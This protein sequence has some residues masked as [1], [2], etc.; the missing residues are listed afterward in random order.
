VYI[1][2]DA[3]CATAY[4]NFEPVTELCAARFRQ[5]SCNGDSGNALFRELRDGRFVAVGTVSYGEGCALPGFPGVY[6][7]LLALQSWVQSVVKV[8]INTPV[9]Y[10][11]ARSGREALS[12]TSTFFTNLVNASALLG[13]RRPSP[14][15]VYQIDPL[16]NLGT[17]PRECGATRVWCHASAVPRECVFMALRSCAHAED[18]FRLGPGRSFVL[19]VQTCGRRT[20]TTFDTVIIAQ[21]SNPYRHGVEANAV[22]AAAV[23]AVLAPRVTPL[24]GVFCAGADCVGRWVPRKRQG[25]KHQ[26]VCGHDP[27]SRLPSRA[28]C[29]CGEH[30][31]ANSRLVLISV[32][33]H[34]V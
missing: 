26:G 28:L 21:D 33:C 15:V 8:P 2:R 12:P 17:V 7:R 18:F 24:C 19:R 10:R 3:E 20:Q 13:T 27:H 1:R 9:R 25:C 32:V 30:R 23:L 29:N 31:R 11:R 14:E 16:L 6:S 5:D 4:R 22:G 34:R